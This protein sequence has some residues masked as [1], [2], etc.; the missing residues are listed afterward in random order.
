LTDHII[1][2]MRIEWISKIENEVGSRW[3]EGLS[4][5]ELNHFLI[6]AAQGQ[7]YFYPGNN[8][9]LGDAFRGYVTGLRYYRERGER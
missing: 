6:W 8:E 4:E 9:K 2:G 7:I 1:E 3:L 5:D